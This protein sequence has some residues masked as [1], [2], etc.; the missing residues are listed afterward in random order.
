MLC[1]ND[2]IIIRPIHWRRPS[3]CPS[4]LA[5][6]FRTGR[7]KFKFVGNILPRACNW[8]FLFWIFEST[9]RDCFTSL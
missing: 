1:I 2:L 8:H 6:N 7:R 5:H 4:R 9:K 3:V